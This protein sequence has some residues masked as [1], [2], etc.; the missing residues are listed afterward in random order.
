MFYLFIFDFA[1][2]TAFEDQKYCGFNKTT[3][4]FLDV[5]EIFSGWFTEKK[6]N[7]SLNSIAKAAG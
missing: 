2:I 1:C 7:K 3:I 4:Y 5:H 6:Y